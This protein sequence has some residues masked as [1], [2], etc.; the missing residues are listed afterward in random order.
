MPKERGREVKEKAFLA[1]YPLI[2]MGVALWLQEYIDQSD[3]SFKA[4]TL[5]YHWST[6][7]GTRQRVCFITKG[8]VFTLKAIVSGTIL[9]VDQK[10]RDS[11]IYHINW[12]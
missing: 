10:L 8:Q 12:T 1:L 3:P 7:T 6:G 5:Y 9:A 11:A 4:A 2:S